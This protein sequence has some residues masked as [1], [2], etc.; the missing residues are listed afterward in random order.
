MKINYLLVLF[1]FVS[2]LQAAIIYVDKDATGN[3][4]GTSWTNA[5]TSIELAF[6]NSLVGDKIWI[7]Q[8]VYK[9]FGTARYTA[10][11]IPNGVEV[12]G[13][14]SGTE[15][16]VN[17]RDLSNGPTTT[18]NGDIGD[19][20]V[21]T[22]NCHS[23]VKF[24]NVSNLTILDGFKIINGYNNDIL[25]G[26]AIFNNGGQP[27]IR[28]C[29]MIANYATRGGAY[30]GYLTGSGIVKFISCK[31]TN[32]SAYYGGAI[33]SN[34]GTLQ[35]IDCDISNNNGTYGGAVN[36]KS[37]E[38]IIDRSI[39]SGNS[40]EYGGVVYLE[41]TLSSI[42]FYNSLMVGNFALAGAVM[43]MS[44]T[45]PSSKVSKI[46]GCTIANNRNTST[47]PSSYLINMPYNK[48]YFQNSILTN[49]ISSKALLNGYVSNS[50]IDGVVSANSSTNLT[51]VAP[52][53]VNPNNA[54]AAPFNHGDYDYRLSDVSIGVNSGD[55]TFV[56]LIYSLDLDGN[57]RIND[58]TVDVGA[59]EKATLGTIDHIVANEK[60]SV[61]PNPVNEIIHFANFI[62]E[63]DYKIY[64][65][66]GQVIT[67]GGVNKAEQTLNFSGYSNGLYFLIT[68]QGDSIK[69][70]KR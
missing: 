44:G 56:N 24:T 8:G 42:E 63:F 12:Y 36:V 20:G 67:E 5:Y 47:A 27:T 28:N 68:S 14:F 37:D 55:N 9:P 45:S 1:L 57:S 64:N 11:N 54:L 41:E 33:H 15:T 22:D 18:L 70:I 4:N 30:G 48:G 49:N 34:G 61:Y 50:I 53:F 17:Q 26:G 69:F 65:T 29:E 10:F 2:N 35:L 46:I 13:S 19:V 59:Y 21:Q 40:A 16:A 23:V 39:L 62:T 60:L 43:S 25:S 66:N 51:T 7:K 58:I 6:G 3:N 32:N 52:T 38:V 31:I